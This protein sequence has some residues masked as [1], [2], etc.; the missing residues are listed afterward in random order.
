MVLSILKDP[1][2]A[3]MDVQIIIDI[4]MVKLVLTVLDLEK[5]KGP[6]MILQKN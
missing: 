1:I 4:E 6:E 2:K 5:S 3:R